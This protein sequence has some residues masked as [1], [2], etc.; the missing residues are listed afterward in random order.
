MQT[1]TAGPILQPQLLA[2]LE[3]PWLTVCTWSELRVYPIINNLLT[4]GCPRT[5]DTG[6]EF[7]RSP[8][9]VSVDPIITILVAACELLAPFDS[10]T[11]LLPPV[12]SVIQSTHI[13]ICSR[14]A[15]KGPYHGF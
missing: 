12:I 15:H 9:L 2:T 8:P 10:L 14:F 13:K 3:R 5:I 4:V 7:R 11:S 1:I 6:A